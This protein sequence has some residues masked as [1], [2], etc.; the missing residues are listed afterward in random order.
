APALINIGTGEEVSIGELALLVKEVT[1]FG[2]E[3]VFDA[4]KP[5]G[6]PR[7][8]CDVSKLHALGWRHRIGLEQGLR[9]TYRW[10]LEAVK[11][12]EKQVTG[13]C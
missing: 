11:S 10:Y 6:S 7:K 12:D 2:G 1:G 9:E 13:D 3:L 8:L 4:S 5:D